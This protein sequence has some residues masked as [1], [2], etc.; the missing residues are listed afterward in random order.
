MADKL[1]PNQKTPDMFRDSFFT[2][3]K[4]YGRKFIAFMTSF[5]LFASLGAAMIIIPLLNPSDVPTVEVYSAF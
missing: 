4:G 5:I 1:G 2:A 3:E